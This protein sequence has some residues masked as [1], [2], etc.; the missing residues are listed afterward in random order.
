MA[1]QSIAGHFS[2]AA[3]S[4]ERLWQCIAPVQD[5]QH[6]SEDECAGGTHLPIETS[7]VSAYNGPAYAHGNLV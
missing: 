7:H 6:T 1:E 5:A 3:G 2:M 4:V